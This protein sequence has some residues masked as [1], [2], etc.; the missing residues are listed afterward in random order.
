M[1]SI[2]VPACISYTF[3]ADND[4]RL[5]TFYIILGSIYM[6]VMVIEVGRF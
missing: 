1:F 4:T 6:G 5:A 3:I 2:V